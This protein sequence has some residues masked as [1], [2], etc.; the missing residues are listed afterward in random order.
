MRYPGI[1]AGR[2]TPPTNSNRKSLT[3]YRGDDPSCTPET[4]AAGSGFVDD[5]G[6]VHL[7]RN[8]GTVDAVV[9]VMSIVPRDAARRIN[10]PQPAAC[11]SIQ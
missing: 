7:V 5:G 3:L 6:D 8:E 9:Y 2:S 10:E 1:F 4:V 11:P